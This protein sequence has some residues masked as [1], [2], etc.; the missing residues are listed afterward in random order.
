VHK[1]R[2]AF[3]EHK[4]WEVQPPIREHKV[5]LDMQDVQFGQ[6]P[7]ELKVPKELQEPPPI[8]VH[9]ELKAH[10]EFKV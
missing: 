10:K 6:V 3:K 1:A 5:R 9:K 7:K 8:P 2:K 4:E